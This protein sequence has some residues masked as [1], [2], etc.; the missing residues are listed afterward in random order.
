MEASPE[1]AGDWIKM[2][3][4]LWDDPRV[5]ALVDA[6]ETTEATIVGGLYWLWATADQ[7]T[8]DGLMPGLSV[9]QIDRKTGIQGFGEA[10][11]SVDWLSEENGG[12]RLA[13]FTEHNGA[14]AKSR[15]TDAQRK[16]RVRTLS[17]NEPDMF[18]TESGQ[19]PPKLGARVRE[20]KSNTP[21]TPTGVEAR[22]EEFW[23]AYPKKT[24]KDAAKKSFMVRKPNAELLGSMLT[25]LTTQKQ[26]RDWQKDSGQYIPNPATWLNQGR[27]MDGEDGGQQ[28]QQE[29][30]V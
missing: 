18:R 22:F 13:R 20:E 2:R 9:R 8:E 23:S 10:L 1:M 25:A 17:G 21:P 19:I 5:G 28:A 30:F 15:A 6:T 3:G 7:H 14:S 11:V 12:V 4:N 27:W 29:T 26:S 24:G 16:A